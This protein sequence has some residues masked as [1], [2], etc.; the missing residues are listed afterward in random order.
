MTPE[1]ET[2]D[3]LLDGDL[4]LKIIR[5]LYPDAAGFKRGAFGLLPSG[6]VRLL[7]IDK[8]EVPK[9]RWRELFVEESAMDELEEM[10][11]TITGQGVSRI[12]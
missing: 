2:L 8:T 10:K 4:S 7:M 9:W 12:A 5:K 6:G 3:Q 11:L 1:L